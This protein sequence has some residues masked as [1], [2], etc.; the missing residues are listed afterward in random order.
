MDTL[1]ICVRPKADE[2]PA[3]SAARN[4]KNRV[5]KKTKKQTKMLR[6]NGPVS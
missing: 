2:Q 3:E 6:R 5:M 1:H 4:K